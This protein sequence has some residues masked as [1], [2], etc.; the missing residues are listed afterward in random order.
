MSQS[1]KSPLGED[2]LT[3]MQA[4]AD[5]LD[6]PLRR[7]QHQIYSGRLPVKRFGQIIT[8]RKSWLDRLFTPE[9][10]A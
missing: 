1:K 3:G 2:L 6:W 8:S 7:V 5:H 10:V 9:K 4:I